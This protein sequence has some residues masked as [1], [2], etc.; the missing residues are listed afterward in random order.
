[1]DVAAEHRARAAQD[2]ARAAAAVL[3]NVRALHL[4]AAE[5]WDEMAR[6][7][8]YG[9]KCAATNKAAKDAD[10]ARGSGRS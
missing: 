3:P 6:Q 2:R 5:T 1:M 8:D 7:T 4:R 10:D 9:S